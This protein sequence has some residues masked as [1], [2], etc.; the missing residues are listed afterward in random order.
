[1]WAGVPA[2]SLARVTRNM[3]L[4]LAATMKIARQAGKSAE[5]TI[6][7]NDTIHKF[8]SGRGVPTRSTEWAI[9]GMRAWLLKLGFEGGL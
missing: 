2:G 3:L 5:Q 9:L 6:S 8:D 7:M 1:M 4:D